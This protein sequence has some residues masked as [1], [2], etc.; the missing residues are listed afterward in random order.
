MEVNISLTYTNSN[1]I[2]RL[3]ADIKKDSIASINIVS[4]P[5]ERLLNQIFI[6]QRKSYQQIREIS[7]EDCL[8]TVFIK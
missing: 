4:Q 5:F 2:I 3:I 6:Y 7:Q 8:L 1:N